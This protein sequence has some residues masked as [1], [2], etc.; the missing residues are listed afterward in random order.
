MNS[1]LITCLLRNIQAEYLR[2]PPLEKRRPYIQ[3]FQC[4]DGNCD[5]NN[6]SEEFVLNGW[7]ISPENIV[8][9]C[10]LSMMPHHLWNFVDPFWAVPVI[11]FWIDKTNSKALIEYNWG[12]NFVRISSFEI[13]GNKLVNKKAEQVY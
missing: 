6:I 13:S 12:E 8:E 3:V 10:C 1:E 2:T 7:K 9:T 11:K 4:R 5:N